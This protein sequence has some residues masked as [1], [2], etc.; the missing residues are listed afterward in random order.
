MQK[1]KN[2]WN[3]D[4]G[5]LIW[6]NSARAIR[7]IPTWQGLNGFQKS[8]HPCALDESGL[9]IR[10]VKIWGLHGIKA[11][12]KYEEITIEK[13]Q[14]VLVIN[15]IKTKVTMGCKYKNLAK[16]DNRSGI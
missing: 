13:G 5:V 1:L 3:S 8:L 7:W 14:V 9:S 16:I 15:L 4:T 11:K 12:I 10:W 2:Y 6:E